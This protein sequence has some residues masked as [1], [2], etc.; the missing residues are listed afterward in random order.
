MGQLD[1]IR[2]S[3]G[4]PPANDDD[5]GEIVAFL[6][7]F[8]LLKKEVADECSKCPADERDNFMLTYAAYLKWVVMFSVTSKFQEEICNAVTPLID[9]ELGKQPWYHAVRVES[10]YDEMVEFPPLEPGG[11]FGVAMPWTSAVVVAN[12]LGLNLSVS[13]DMRFHIYVS[14]ITKQLLETMSKVEPV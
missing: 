2:Q 10:L 9:R 14:V 4:M 3:L 12:S 5:L 13:E 7:L 11:T 6:V 8:Q 1:Q